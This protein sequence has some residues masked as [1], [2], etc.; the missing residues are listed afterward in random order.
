M[1]N[2]IRG[3]TR[4]LVS[5]IGAMALLAALTPLVLPGPATAGTGSPQP[6]LSKTNDADHDGIYHA[7]EN[8][9]KNVSYPWTVSYRLSVF[10]G[11]S[12]G[13]IG[14][15]HTI[16]S[17]TDNR[18]SNIGSCQALI[19]TRINDNQTETCS[20][21]VT[22]TGPAS[23]PLTNTATLIYDNG[24]KDTP[25]SSSTV[26]FPALTLTKSSTT[27]LITSVGQTVPYSYVIKNTGTVA[28]T[29]VLLA[30]NKTNSPPSCPATTLAVGASMTC[31]GQTTVTQAEITAGGS[32]VNVATVSSNE[33]PNATATVSIPI[34]A[35]CPASPPKVNVRWHYS[36]NGTS[37]SWS[38]TQSASCGQT[39]SM[40]PQAMEGNLMVSPGTTLMAGYD[41]TLPGNKS[42]FT[43]SF[44]NGKVVFAVHCVSGATPSQPTFTVGLPN[45]SYSVTDSNWYPSGQQSSSLVYQGQIAVP[46]LC[47]GGVLRL[48]QGGTFSAFMTIH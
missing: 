6:S 8:V 41:F 30:D 33:A 5:V 26:N 3:R 48:D 18:T 2:R 22:L 36:A 42:P 39:I 38:G 24:G 46:D 44:S 15:F 17:I 10:G 27:Q 37:G 31:T 34:Q 29:G 4:R 7:T 13:P 25:R 20:Y 32:L 23:S 35:A 14:P 9:P 1:N 47:A 19:G 12:P 45:Q 43:V 21:N 16:T 28:L 11:T 40:G